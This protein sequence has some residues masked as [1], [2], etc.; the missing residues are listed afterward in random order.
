VEL[1][2]INDRTS[3]RALAHRDSRRADGGRKVLPALLLAASF[4]LALAAGVAPAPVEARDLLVLR[5]ELRRGELLSCDAT[6]CRLGNATIPRHDIVLIGLDDPP[7]PAPSIRNPVQDELH[8]RDG[9]VR[10]GPLVSLDAR[11]VVT[12]VRAYE[13][14]EVRWI[15][16][17][18]SPAGSAGDGGAAGGG[19]GV[20]GGAGGE[21]GTCGFWLGT[22]GRRGVDR[23]SDSDSLGAVTRLTRT[24]RTVYTVRLREGP[25]SGDLELRLDDATVR[26]RLREVVSDPAGGNRTEG[27]GTSHIDGRTSDGLLVLGKPSRP[28]SYQFNVGTAEYRYP[29]TT[30]WSSGPPTRHQELFTGIWVGKDPDPEQPRILDASGRMMK[31]EYTVTHE[32]GE[33]TSL[34]ESVSWELTR[35]STTCDAP[36]PLPAESEPPEDAE[37]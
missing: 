21:D 37:P 34:T 2:G 14:R 25:R 22:V 15:Y 29:S 35:V 3:R 9:S 19:G 8:L 27:S 16:L 30:H 20:G 33:R 17:A 24:V 1:T 12:P 31:G 6:A 4:M 28:S 5:T 13:R 11:R 32:Y 36:P 26:E 18:P 10:P 23:H 7:L